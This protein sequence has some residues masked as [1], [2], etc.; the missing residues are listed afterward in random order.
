MGAGRGMGGSSHL[1]LQVYSRAWDEDYD[2][3]ES[4]Y[5]AKGWNAKEMLHFMK[6]HERVFDEPLLGS[7]KI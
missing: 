2:R 4:I 3:W 7:G 1:N 6:K 5:G